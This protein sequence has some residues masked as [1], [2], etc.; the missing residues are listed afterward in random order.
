MVATASG[1]VTSSAERTYTTAM[2]VIVLVSVISVGNI[3]T[4]RTMLFVQ[5]NMKPC[6]VSGEMEMST[7]RAVESVSMHV[8][9]PVS[10][11]RASVARAM[12]GSEFR[13]GICGAG[14]RPFG[15]LLA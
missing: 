5:T 3:V 11:E 1:I 7:L 9:V 2:S 15:G 14:G 12:T 6:M 4:S 10:V 13:G 8:R